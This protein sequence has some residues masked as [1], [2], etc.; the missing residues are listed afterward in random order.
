MDPEPPPVVTQSIARSVAQ[1]RK[2]TSQKVGFHEIQATP[3][4][5]VWMRPLTSPMTAITINVMI[6][7]RVLL[8]NFFHYYFFFFYY[9]YYY[10]NRL[11]SPRQCSLP[12][13]LQFSDYLHR[14]PQV[15]L[16]DI[17]TS[18][19]AQSSDERQERAEAA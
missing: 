19:K 16:A 11:E 18:V 3:R 10:T 4:Q 2:S 13:P 9:Y 17:L 14:I 5:L 12:Y 15:L 6:A 7:S 8:Y 1:A